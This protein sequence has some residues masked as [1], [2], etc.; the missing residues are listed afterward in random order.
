[1]R[2]SSIALQ[3]H[4]I[5]LSIEF[6]LKTPNFENYFSQISTNWLID[7]YTS[8]II[9]YNDQINQSNQPI[10]SIKAQLNKNPKSGTFK[11]KKI[12]NFQN[13]QIDQINS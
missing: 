1:M 10:S 12:K 13:Q 3:K 11:P 6:I 2:I 5:D 8:E 9:V 7:H 4:K